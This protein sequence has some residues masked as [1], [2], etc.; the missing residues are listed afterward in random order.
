MPRHR[1][2]A[3]AACLTAFAVVAVPARAATVSVSGTY[4]V[5]TDSGSE[6]N[7]LTITETA[8]NTVTVSDTSTTPTPSG[9]C[10]GTAPVTCTL[11]GQV[12]QL[13]VNA[14]GGDDSITT[15]SA[16]AKSIVNGG[17]GIDTIASNG[18]GGSELTG[19]PGADAFTATVDPNGAHGNSVRYDLPVESAR[20]AGV[21]VTLDGVAND[22]STPYDGTSFQALDRGGDNV[23]AGI[24][25]VY[26][27]AFGD[28]L[29]GDAAQNVLYGLAGDDILS[30][31]GEYDTLLGAAGADTITGGAGQDVMSG[32]P[33]SD[34]LFAQDGEADLQVSCDGATDNPQGASD[35]ALADNNDVVPSNPVNGG[36]ETLTRGN[37]GGD[38]TPPDT[39]I[40]DGPI[41]GTT[42]TSANFAFDTSPHEANATF[43]CSIDSGPY[44]LCTSPKTYAGLAAGTTH[45]FAVYATDAASNS[46]A[47]AA[48]HTWDIVA[49]TATSTAT[50]VVTAT[51]TP[52]RRTPRRS[53]RRSPRSATGS[54]RR[55][56]ARCNP[57]R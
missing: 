32:G 24:I 50:A 45:S 3:L 34:S 29:T 42:S 10:S 37:G 2:A 43:H 4:V 41:D 19:G 21:N 1:I 20:A 57:A 56:P 28:S 27:T 33:D 52:T 7:T 31:G 53:R 30:G 38:T 47:S 13:Q 39:V 15:N 55:P 8:G 17:D 25:L 48:V 23:G 16:N 14:G 5:V 6:T 11:G 12:T 49:P 26:G 51:A 44:T 54:P 9:T 46:D 22:G 36:C 18:T 35:S 40:T